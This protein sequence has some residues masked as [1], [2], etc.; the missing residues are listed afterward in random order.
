MDIIEK[1]WEAQRRI[2][3]RMKHIGKGKYGRVLKLSR[4]PTVD[5]FN[6]IVLITGLGVL[7]IGGL[8]FLIWRLWF[9]FT[10]ILYGVI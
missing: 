1:S 4:K 5:E 7:L 10:D 8:G 2:E 9:T 3:K 6:K